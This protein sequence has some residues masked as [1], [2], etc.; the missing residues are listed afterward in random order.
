MIWPAGRRNPNAP[1]SRSSMVY[2]NLTLPAPLAQSS[3]P[4]DARSARKKRTLINKWTPKWIGMGKFIHRGK[5]V[6][7]NEWRECKTSFNVWRKV[8]ETCKR[9]TTERVCW[10]IY[11]VAVSVQGRWTLR[12]MKRTRQGDSY[13]QYYWEKCFSPFGGNEYIM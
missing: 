1:V 11:A 9:V 10:E 12:P 8:E 7:E 6:E 3:E 13:V 2:E 4:P 5:Q